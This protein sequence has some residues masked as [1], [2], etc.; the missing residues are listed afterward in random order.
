MK[1]RGYLKFSFTVC[2]AL[3]EVVRA[4]ILSTGGLASAGDDVADDDI[5]AAE[6]SRHVLGLLNDARAR[7]KTG[8]LGRRLYEQRFDLRH[9]LAVLSVSAGAIAPPAAGL[10]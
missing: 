7:A 2:E 9:T 5:A 1:N 6:L 3:Y 8:E 10:G 4:A